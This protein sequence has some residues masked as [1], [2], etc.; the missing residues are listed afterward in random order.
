M[1]FQVCLRGKKPSVKAAERGSEQRVYN[2]LALYNSSDRP[3]CK[4]Q[5]PGSF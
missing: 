5:K 4:A 3:E 2:T 1:D